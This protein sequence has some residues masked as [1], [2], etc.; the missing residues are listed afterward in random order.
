MRNNDAGL[1][2]DRF[3]LGRAVAYGRLFNPYIGWM[4]WLW[5]LVSLGVS[6]VCIICGYSPLGV[7]LSSL[8]SF[9]PSFMIYFGPMVF[10]IGSNQIVETLVP[11]KW[12]EKASVVVVMSLVVIPCLV[13]VPGRVAMWIAT[14]LMPNPQDNLYLE[15][16]SVMPK[17]YGL[18]SYFQALIPTAA[19]M[20][21]VTAYTHRRMLLGGVWAVAS[22]FLLGLGGMIVGGY[23]AFKIGMEHGSSGVPPTDAEQLVSAIIDGLTW[24]LWVVGIAGVIYLGLMIWLTCRKIKNRQI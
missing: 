9:I 2:N 1:W 20:L 12:S 23:A 18:A 17:V 4:L 13:L 16:F 5:P 8:L 24:L 3:S 19:C 22:L 21:A 6:V 7:I 11:A 10:A 15:M 14:L